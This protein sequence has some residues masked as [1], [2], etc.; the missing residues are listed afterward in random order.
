MA[1]GTAHSK[2]LRPEVTHLV[3]GM[4]RRPG[5]LKHRSKSVGVRQ[6]K[7]KM[8]EGVEATVRSTAIIPRELGSPLGD[9]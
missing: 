3:Q 8:Q 6:R 2:A 5:R 9:L 1:E 4:G 7:E